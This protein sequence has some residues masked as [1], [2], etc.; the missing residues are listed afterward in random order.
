DVIDSKDWAVTFMLLWYTEYKQNNRTCI[1]VHNKNDTTGFECV[2]VAVW[3][4]DS[5]ICLVPQAR[6]VNKWTPRKYW[7]DKY[8]LIW[9]NWNETST[10]INSSELS[11]SIKSKLIKCISE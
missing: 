1:L 5:W 10:I 7:G 2:M 4:Y 8:N 11:S 9:D 3:G 6:N